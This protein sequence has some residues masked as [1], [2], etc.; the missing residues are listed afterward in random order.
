MPSKITF[1]LGTALAWIA[2]FCFVET[3]L[4]QDAVTVPVAASD[5]DDVD[6]DD[7]DE[8]ENKSRRRRSHRKSSAVN[9]IVATHARLGMW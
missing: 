6:G 2:L 4:S 3:G 5:N 7:N 8:T 9:P 1:A